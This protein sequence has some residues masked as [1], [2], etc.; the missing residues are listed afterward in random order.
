MEI[1]SDDTQAGIFKA[2]LTK[3]ELRN[4]VLK[5]SL[6][7]ARQLHFIFFRKESDV[8]ERAQAMLLGIDS[9]RGMNDPDVMPGKYGFEISYADLSST[10]LAAT[11]EE[12][13]DFAYHGMVFGTGSTMDSESSPAWISMI[14]VDL[15]RS[16]FAEEWNQYAPSLEAVRTLQSVCECAQ[17]RMVL[18][19][20]QQGDCFMDW[21]GREA[22][23]GLTFRQMALLS[24]MSEAS[25]RTL[26]NPKRNNP[27]K[28]H[29]DG[30]NTFI[31]PEDAKAWLISKG[32]YVPLVNIDGAGALFDLATESIS[33]IDD[34]ESR[35]NSRLHFM[36][37]SDEGPTT[38]ESLLTIRSDLI[39]R[40]LSDQTPY[41]NLSP[42]DMA[43]S[44]LLNKI[45]DA[46]QLPGEL[47]SLKAA[48]L[49]AAQKAQELQRRFDDAARNALK[50]A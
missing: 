5:V 34:L 44:K 36:L 2:P 43:N 25:L 37:G 22:H 23:D 30:R 47:L 9:T 40:R 11:M 20:I 14:L 17:A 33:S 49:Y 4:H 26:A 6:L 42:D 27:L 7:L 24:G 32:R 21:H 48:Y 41:L 39:G 1:P 13:Y 50:K 46:L 45:A 3:L 18:E 12:L 38:N 15:S 8:H 10:A 29:S 28:T 19:D 31:E 35:L 16:H